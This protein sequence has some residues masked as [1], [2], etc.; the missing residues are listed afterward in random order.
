M[1][2]ASKSGDRRES[3]TGRPAGDVAYGRGA[4]IHRA[5]KEGNVA[6]P[7][8]QC[9]HRYAPLNNHHDGALRNALRRAWLQALSTQGAVGAEA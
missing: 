4:P 5:A 7:E 3:W 8:E 9:I 2:S 6:G 1:P